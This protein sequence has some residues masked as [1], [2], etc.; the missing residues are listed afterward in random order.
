MDGHNFMKGFEILSIS[1]DHSKE[2][3]MSEI[4]KQKAPWIQTTILKEDK[5]EKYDPFESDIAK[6]YSVLGVPSNNLINPDG[7][8]MIPI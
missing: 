8:I 1:L 7:V 2:K 5:Y 3:W 4:E 6:A